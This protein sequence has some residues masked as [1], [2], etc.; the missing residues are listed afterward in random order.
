M[1]RKLAL[2]VH[3]RA[4]YLDQT[5]VIICKKHI[6]TCGQMFYLHVQFITCLNTCVPVWA[7][8]HA[9]RRLSCKGLLF[10][11]TVNYA[12]YIETRNVF[13]FFFVVCYLSEKLNI[14]VH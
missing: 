5:Q 11:S 1:R 2:S 4:R 12:L 6:K 14:K 7:Y 8:A 13:Y 10:C 9:V 3:N